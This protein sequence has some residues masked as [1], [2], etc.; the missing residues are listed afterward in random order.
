VS[1]TARAGVQFVDL[2]L[3]TRPAA[4]AAKSKV[5]QVVG[6]HRQPS[7][8]SP[9]APRI[10]AGSVVPRVLGQ[11]VLGPLSIGIA[12]WPIGAVLVALSAVAVLACTQRGVKPS[13]S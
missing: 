11:F 13:R 7:L 8:S 9:P 12:P 3:T 1:S 10:P 6:G 2:P 4:A 5:R